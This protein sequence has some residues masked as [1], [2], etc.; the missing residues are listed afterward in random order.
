M[1]NTEETIAGIEETRSL[2]LTWEA[3][4]EIKEE[5]ELYN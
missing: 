1:I 4:M 3:E 5:Q 2:L